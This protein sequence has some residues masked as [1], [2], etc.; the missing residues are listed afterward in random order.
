[1]H[2][3]P[4]PTADN[5]ATGQAGLYRPDRLDAAL[6]HNQ[7]ARTALAGRHPGPGTPPPRAVGR[8]DEIAEIARNISQVAPEFPD[9]S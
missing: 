1:M 4:A 9:A 8:R 7:E 2:D 6:L 5:R 3:G